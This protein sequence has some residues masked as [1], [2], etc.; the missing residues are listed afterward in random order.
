VRRRQNKLNP[1]YQARSVIQ[2]NQYLLARY[3]PDGLEKATQWLS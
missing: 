1:L 2:K 3:I